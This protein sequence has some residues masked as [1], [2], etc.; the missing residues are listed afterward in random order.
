MNLAQQAMGLLVERLPV[1][2]AAAVIVF[3]IWW[4]FVRKDD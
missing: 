2:C 4:V 1:I 3:V